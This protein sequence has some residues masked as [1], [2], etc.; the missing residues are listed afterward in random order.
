MLAKPKASQGCD[1]NVSQAG[2]TSETSP[3]VERS[4]DDDASVAIVYLIAISLGSQAISIMGAQYFMKDTLHLGPA[5]VAFY[6]S[7]HSL[8][9]VLKPL[10]G[11]ITDSFPIRGQRRK[12]YLIIM[13]AG[14]ALGF[15]AFGYVQHVWDFVV[16]LVAINACL[17]FLTVI[18]QAFMVQRSSSQDF[19]G[20]SYLFS[21]YFGIKIIAS[22]CLTYAAGYLLQT[23]S[24]R[25]VLMLGAGLLIINVLVAPCIREPPLPELVSIAEQCRS[26]G[27]MFQRQE[28]WSMTLYIFVVC[29]MPSPT[30]AMFYFNVDVLKFDPEFIACITICSSLASVVGLVLYHTCFTGVPIRTLF[31]VASVLCTIVSL[32]PLIQI[33]RWN[34]QWGIDDRVFALVDTFFITAVAE[35]LWIP[36]LVIASRLCPT[37]VEGTTYALFLSIHNT[38]L[39]FSGASSGLLTAGLGITREDLSSLWILVTI[40]AVMTLTPI[41]LLPLFPQG[42]AEMIRNADAAEKPN[43]Q[44]AE[45]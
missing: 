42:N 44:D 3:L 1:E 17:A 19:N 34:R 5:E 36:M 9:W 26:I 33:F 4:K 35:V 30:A 7:F 11:M 20:A 38:G 39:W 14:A 45:A 2:M 43:P 32:T 25:Q 37:S 12:P 15:L 41:A 31:C 21:M 10:W 8:G 23:H 22:C 6:W 29:A 28:V 16:V 24:A 40:C 13:S 27:K 18:A